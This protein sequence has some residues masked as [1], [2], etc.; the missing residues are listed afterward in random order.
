MSKNLTPGASN[1][2]HKKLQRYY[3]DSGT[4]L[5]KY[6]NEEWQKSMAYI[7]KSSRRKTEASNRINTAV[8]TLQRDTQR[9]LYKCQ[10]KVVSSFSN[11]IEEVV[12]WEKKLALLRNLILVEITQMESCINHL[13][14][15][16]NE[17]FDWTINS[18][19]KCLALREKRLGIDLVVDDPEI[20]LLHEEKFLENAG[21]N[22]ISLNKSANEV[23][24]ALRDSLHNVESD[25]QRKD[26]ALNIG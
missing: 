18:N 14:S 24:I 8:K 15:Y 21:D 5:K 22:L 20:E 1:I 3:S 23:L 17:R 4:S 12:K 2:D 11:R 10:T 13:V 19:A 25:I 16:R 26:E 6:Q 9:Q 7:S